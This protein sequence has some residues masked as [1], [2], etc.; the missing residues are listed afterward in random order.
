LKSL[1]R[2]LACLITIALA[3]PAT[4][5][6][7]YPTRNITLIVP[8]AAGGPTD[9]IARIVGAHMSQTLG[10][11]IVIQ[12]ILGAGGTTA[13]T[14]AM[15]VAPDGYTLVMGHMA[16]MPPRS[17]SIP[18]LPTSPMRISSRSAWRPARRCLSSARKIFRR[19]ISRNSSP[20]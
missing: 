7:D 15:R 20:M 5:Q 4:A 2:A 9:I 18:I 8:F 1:F 11:Q 14:Q 12:N 16:P 19:P 3:A 10:Q 13:S 17:R 6:S